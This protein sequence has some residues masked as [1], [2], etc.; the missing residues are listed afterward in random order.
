MC[1]VQH[2]RAQNCKFSL[3]NVLRINLWVVLHKTLA[4]RGGQASTSAFVTSPNDHK[5]KDKNRIFENIYTW[6]AGLN[7]HTKKVG[8]H[9]AKS[10][11]S[12]PPATCALHSLT[13]SMV[14]FKYVH[15]WVMLFACVFIVE[16]SVARTFPGQGSLVFGVFMCNRG[17][18]CGKRFMCLIVSQLNPLWICAFYG[19]AH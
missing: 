10:A 6:A 17:P 18:H 3:D 8:W 13:T 5:Q 19:C 4:F 12:T 7:K 1:S 2:Y 11:S 14:H 16:V 15:T 9:A